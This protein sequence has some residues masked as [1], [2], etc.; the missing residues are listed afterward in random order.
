MTSTMKLMNS[1]LRTRSARVPTLGAQRRQGVTAVEFALIAPIFFL[2]FLGIIESSLIMLAEHLMENA[3]YNASRVAKTGYVEENKTQLETVTAA[4]LAEMGSLEPLIEVSKLT[5]TT[6][7]Y[8]SMDEIGQAGQGTQGLGEA[9]QIL[10]LTVSY[11]WQVFTP[12]LGEFIGDENNVV[13]LSTQIMVR[14]EPYS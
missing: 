8:G 4:L 5:F 6:V 9:E 10:V 11:P 7:S 14:N 13:K 2:F 3:A 12:M 1:I